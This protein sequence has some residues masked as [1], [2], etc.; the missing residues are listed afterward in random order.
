MRNEAGKVAPRLSRGLYFRAEIARLNHRGFLDSTNAASA[1]P[2]RIAHNTVL[3]LFGLGVPLLV[4]FFVMP[5]ALHALGAARFGLLGL[6]WAATEYLSLFD[7]GMGRATVRFVAEAFAAGREGIGRTAATSVITQTATGIV[8]AIVFVLVTPFVVTHVFSVPDALRP[9]AIA[10][11]KIVALNLPIVLLLSTLRG[12]LEGVQRFDMSNGIKIATSSAAVIIP[13]LAA[14]AGIGLPTIM[15]LILLSRTA[16][17]IAM[18]YAI[19]RAIPGFRWAA[20]NDWAY[21]KRMLLF[22]GWVSVSSAVSP[23]L[24]YFDRFSLAAVAGLAA[25]GYY[26]APYEG[27][28]RLLLIP[29]S[30]IGTLFPALTGEEAQG[31]RERAGELVSR[32]NRHLMLAMAPPIAIIIGLS[33]LLLRVWLGADAAANSGTAL[34]ILAVGVFVNALAHPS[35]VFLYA[36][37]RPDLPAKFHLTELC[38]HLPLTWLLVSKFGVAGAAL[39]WA[40]R[41]TIDWALLTFFARKKGRALPAAFAERMRRAVYVVALLVVTT[42]VAALLLRSSSAAAVIAMALGVAAYAAVAWKSALDDDE[43]RL[44]VSMGRWYLGAGRKIT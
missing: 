33:P 10:M 31:N 18:E 6:A 1:A 19:R 20:P 42:L 44:A 23:I 17:C 43:R 9:E 26:T 7:L 5:L 24:V 27:V 30:V 40:T 28:S 12:V 25:V 37:G 38:I 15:L 35:Y 3:N 32:A 14:R 21:V 13:A 39:A 22:G 2:S 41:V 34:R 8:G 16:G 29:I 4:A 11:F 36:I